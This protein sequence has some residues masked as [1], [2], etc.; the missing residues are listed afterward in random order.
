MFQS[1]LPKTHVIV[2]VLLPALILG[3]VGCSASPNNSDGST[4]DTTSASSTSHA[5]YDGEALLRGLVFGRGPVGQKFPEFWD[6][7]RQATAA[8]LSSNAQ[9]E[10]EL[11]TNIDRATSAGDTSTAAALT[12]MRDRVHRGEVDVTKLTSSAEYNDAAGDAKIDAVVAGIKQV[13][14]GF[15]PWFAT[16]IQSGDRLRIEGALEHATSTLMAAATAH[17]S[18]DV[19]GTDGHTKG[20]CAVVVIV[21]AIVA[22]IALAIAVTIKAPPPKQSPIKGGGGGGTLAHDQFID[23]IAR[24]LA[25]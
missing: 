1:L 12:A 13:D 17:P 15:F 19:F 10:A 11:T 6:G 7:V 22:V 21:A 23:A 25:T 5:K 4:G 20:D 18:A 14:P 8:T 16:E 2:A 24:R 3:Q 9:F